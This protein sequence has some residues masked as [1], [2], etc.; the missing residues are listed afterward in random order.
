MIAA[1]ESDI[2]DPASR[3]L[4]RKMHPL[5][6]VMHYGEMSGGL[7]DLCMPKDPS[8][9][10]ITWN[11]TNGRRPNG[12]YAGRELEMV[13]REAY[14]H[15]KDELMRQCKVKEMENGRIELL[16]MRQ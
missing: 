7:V 11:W 10:S 6:R 9:K 16:R 3:E 13:L 12:R 14:Q 15:F 8:I 4:F 2:E 5:I 1:N